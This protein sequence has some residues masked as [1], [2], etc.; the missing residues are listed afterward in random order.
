M[1]AT[2]RKALEYLDGLTN[3]GIKP[4]L[5]RMEALAGSLGDPQKCAPVVHITGTN[6]K[7]ST[8]RIISAV[9]QELGLRTGTYTSPHLQVVNERIALDL[10]PLGDQNF[11]EAFAHAY[12]GVVELD[13]LR[14]E[15]PSYFEMVTLMAFVA[16]ADAPVGVQVVEVGM[17]GRWD[18][19]NIA[20]ADVAVVTN[21]SVDH[22]QYLGTTPP[23]IA[24]EKAGIIKDGTVLVVGETDPELVAIFESVA[25]DAGASRVV[26]N[27]VDFR[28]RDR[29][30]AVGGQ[31]VSIEGIYGEYTDLFLPIFG[32]F[33]AE[34]ATVALAACEALIKG[35]VDE[36]CVEAALQSVTTPGRMEVASRRPLVILDGAHNPA[37]L[38][39]SLEAIREAFTYDRLLVV[40]GVFEDKDYSAMLSSI[41]GLGAS[42]FTTQTTLARAAPASLIASVARDLGIERVDSHQDVPS[43]VDAARDAA[44]DG[45]LILVTGSLYMVGEARTHLL[46]APEI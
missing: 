8:A 19:T 20:D 12:V 42:L 34:N 40:F 5:E 11:A 4:G 38:A 46:G 39:A 2:Y 44:A 24:A 35:A 16:F 28:L 1:P 25:G 15:K 31:T 18:A 32:R 30:S 36:K 14:G 9:L 21:V 26:K 17:G 22:A 27:G 41:A 37:G 45:D 23:L 33:Q 6:G 13:R 43:A 7:T 10:R 29:S 3:L